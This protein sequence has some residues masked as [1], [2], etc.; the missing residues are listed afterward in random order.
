MIAGSL[1]GGVVGGAVAGAIDS[2]ESRSSGMQKIYIDSL[3]GAYIF[4]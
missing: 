1:I 4:D 2:K 3:T